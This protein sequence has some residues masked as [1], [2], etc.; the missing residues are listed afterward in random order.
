VTSV[1]IASGTDHL[2]VEVTGTK[3]PDVVVSTIDALIRPL[4]DDGS[5]VSEGSCSQTRAAEAGTSVTAARSVSGHGATAS[6]SPVKRIAA[7]VSSV[8]KSAASLS[9][10][11]RKRAAQPQPFV[12]ADT[13]ERGSGSGS[14]EESPNALRTPSVGSGSH[15]TSVV[16]G[17]IDAGTSK[18]QHGASEAGLSDDVR[19]FVVADATTAKVF[20]ELQTMPLRDVFD[21]PE[22]AGEVDAQCPPGIVLVS[23]T[24][25]EMTDLPGLRLLSY[26]WASV[27]E[28]TCGAKGPGD[29]GYS[30]ARPRRLAVDALRVF[31]GTP[32]TPY[33]GFMWVDFL[34]HLDDPQS[35]KHVLGR[36]VP[37]TTVHHHSL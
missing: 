33:A 26:R 14:A 18:T 30:P 20:P 25:T 9:L 12:S 6:P 13:D 10:T 22:W 11:G 21:A 16:P 2:A 15:G 28:V 5:V 23:T 24:F 31:R 4:S 35:K 19:A 32:T 34:C 17:F 8:I 3:P 1:Y 37:L 29:E 27:L 36:C 7:T